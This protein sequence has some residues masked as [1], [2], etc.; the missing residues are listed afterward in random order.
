[1]YVRLNKNPPSQTD[2]HIVAVKKIKAYVRYLLYI[3]LANPN[4]FKIMKADASNIA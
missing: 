1:M 4:Y 2:E 3:H